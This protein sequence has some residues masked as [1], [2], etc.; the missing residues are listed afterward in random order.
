VTGTVIVLPHHPDCRA[1]NGEPG[2]Y[3]FG[4]SLDPE[5]CCYCAALIRGEAEPLDFRYGGPGCGCK[6]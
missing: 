5:R 4:P 3:P 1:A 2:S 6:P